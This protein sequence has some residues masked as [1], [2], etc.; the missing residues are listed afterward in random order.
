MDKRNLEMINPFD[1]DYD[2]QI[3]LSSL[4]WKQKLGYL[5]TKVEKVSSKFPIEEKR[6]QSEE[7]YKEFTEF[8]NQYLNDSVFRKQF[9]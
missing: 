5:P 6:K 1:L 9:E 7:Y 4:Y 8:V 2:L 3:E